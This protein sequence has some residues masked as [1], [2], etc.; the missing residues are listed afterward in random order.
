MGVCLE[1][2]LPRA[3]YTQ[4][5]E[6]TTCPCTIAR[7]L[8]SVSVR[9]AEQ[10]A[11]TARTRAI[12]GRRSA[13]LRPSR[14]PLSRRV[15]T[16]YGTAR[17]SL[18]E[19]AGTPRFR[20]E[21]L[22]VLLVLLALLSAYV[23]GRGGD[24]GRLVAWWGSSLDRSLGRASFLVPVLIALAALRA[25]GG[26]SGRV[27]EGRHYLGGFAFAVAVVGL[28]QLGG[29]PKTEQA[30]G[31]LG[32]SV[33]TLATR[34][35]GPFGAGLALFAA[36]V[37]AIFLL[38]G[39]DF[40]TFSN[41]VRAL[42]RAMWNV[43]SAMVAVMADVQTKIRRFAPSLQSLHEDDTGKDTATVAVSTP[44]VAER[45]SHSRVLSASLTRVADEEP[46][47]PVINVTVRSQPSIPTPAP[48]LKP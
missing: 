44:D 20:R 17:A 19:I 12:P 18:P 2:K 5:L 32:S 39:S 42:G 40:Q 1:A 16:F 13:G 3:M 23:I 11:T 24:E 28:L 6:R 10:M 46:A 37:L 21:L 48:I 36:G 43:V 38:A 47:S 26:Q 9:L 41:D 22:G 25:F 30:G 31:A 45:S 27:L 34:I 14:T 4:C 8:T 35:L 7:H 29:R 33:A 15:A